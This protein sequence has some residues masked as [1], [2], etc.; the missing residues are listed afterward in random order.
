[1]LEECLQLLYRQPFVDVQET[2]VQDGHRM[3]GYILNHVAIYRRATIKHNLKLEATG[4]FL[5]IEI[6][7]ESEDKA[8]H[9]IEAENTIQLFLCLKICFVKQDWINAKFERV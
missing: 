9:E 1:M 7:K 8:R 3:I 5:T 2:L 6:F 4:V